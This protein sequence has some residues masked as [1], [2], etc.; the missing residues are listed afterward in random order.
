M[1]KPK[2][3]EPLTRAK[4]TAFTRFDELEQGV[5]TPAGWVKYHETVLS[6]FEDR[7]GAPWR[8]MR[9]YFNRDDKQKGGLIVVKSQVTRESTPFL[10]MY[11]E[12][13]ELR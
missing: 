7:Q 8:V 3:E 1:A 6:R 5:L 12:T 11:Q 9:M 4:V 10:A 13:E 2:A